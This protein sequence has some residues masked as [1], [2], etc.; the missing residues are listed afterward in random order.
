MCAVD[1]GSGTKVW[2]FATQDTCC[3]SPATSSDG[4]TLCIGCQDHCVHAIDAASGAKV[5]S[6]LTG[7]TVS[8]SPRLSPDGKTLCAASMGTRVYAMDVATGRLVWKL[9][10]N[11]GFQASPALSAD[12]K[13][14]HVGN[15]LGHMCAI[16][17][18]SSTCMWN[19]S[20]PNVATASATLSP[21][22]STLHFGCDDGNVHAAHAADGTKVWTFTT[23]AE[24]WIWSSPILS[25]DGR[26]LHVGGGDHKVHAT[27][28]A[29]GTKAWSHDKGRWA[30]ERVLGLLPP[31]LRTAVPSTFVNHTLKL[32]RPTPAL[33]P[34]QS[35]GWCLPCLFAWFR[36]PGLAWTGCQK[37]Q[38]KASK[39]PFDF[40]GVSRVL[41]KCVSKPHVSRPQHAARRRVP[42]RADASAECGTSQPLSHR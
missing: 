3:S 27:D 7:L 9:P 24:C 1:A 16:D 17:T 15:S 41:G 36:R 37:T 39:A 13:S 33:I 38:V 20:L 21:D 23:N 25:A 28:T 40:R 26:V 6:F 42:L 19:I 14:L 4:K 18:A 32:A 11:H 30:I 35:L 2:P 31:S 10:T 5:W 34:P 29:S 8:S 22:G 12:G